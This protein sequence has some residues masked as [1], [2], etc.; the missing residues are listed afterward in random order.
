MLLRRH[1]RLAGGVITLTPRR[2]LM[3]MLLLLRS[4]PVLLVTTF[5]TTGSRARADFEFQGDGA[6]GVEICLR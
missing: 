6:S 1:V 4:F 3:C 2:L 5:P